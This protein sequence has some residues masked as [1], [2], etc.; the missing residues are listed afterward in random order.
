M[1]RTRRLAIL[2]PLM[3][4][5][6]ALWPAVAAHAATGQAP[7]LVPAKARC[8]LGQDTADSKPGDP[9]FTLVASGLKSDAVSF[10]FRG[11]NGGGGGSSAQ[12]VTDGSISF[13]NLSP[14]TYSIRGDKDGTVNCGRT[15]GAKSEQKQAKDQ[16]KKGFSDGFA[17]IRKNCESKP[18]Q[19]LTAVDPNYEKGFNDGAALAAKQFCKA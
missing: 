13:N 17:A 5:S 11:A 3:V 2:A 16:Y 4:S 6:L 19:G 8:A 18:P 12:P 9:R 15:P 7:G 1:I 10:S 14:G